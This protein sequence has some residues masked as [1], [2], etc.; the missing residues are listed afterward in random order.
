MVKFQPL[1][2]GVSLCVDSL[3]EAFSEEMRGCTPTGEVE[4]SLC[5]CQER[6][7]SKVRDT[8]DIKS[9]QVKVPVA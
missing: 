7:D 4:I 8:L 5:Y 6:R 9:L 1:H 2:Q 3:C